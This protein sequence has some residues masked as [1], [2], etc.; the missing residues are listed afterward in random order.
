MDDAELRQLMAEVKGLRAELRRIFRGPEQET[1]A[2]VPVDVKHLE[3]ATPSDEDL[4]F[5]SVSGPLPSEARA[6]AQKSQ[7]IPQE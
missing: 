2:V 7:P 5:W 4:L 6:E 1:R 3:D